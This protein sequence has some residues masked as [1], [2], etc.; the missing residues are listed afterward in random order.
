MVLDSETLR[1][2]GT[3]E[4][5]AALRAD[6][7]RY[8]ETRS[9]AL[10]DVSEDGRQM[11]VTT[12]FGQTSQVH[13]VKAPMAARTQLTFAA[14][15]A[16]S[17]RFVPGDPNAIVYVAD[18][19]GDEQYQ[20]WR[21]DLRTGRRVRLTDA[22]SRNGGALWSRD[23]A[24][25]AYSS[26]S[27]NKRDF[28]IWV[29][30][31]RDPASAQRIVD[32]KGW[33]YPLDWSRDGKKLLIGEYI[34]ANE[35]RLYVV[36]VASRAL[37]R[38][39]PEGKATY[40][41][42]LFAADGQRVYVVSDRDGEFGSLYESDLTGSSW[43]PLT[44]DIPWNV[45]GMDVS[46][47]GRT[48]A[49]TINQD[50]YSVLHLLDTRR[51]RHRVVDALPKGLIGGLQFV[52]KG[53]DTL[54]FTLSSATRSGDAYT[55][56]VRRKTLTRWTE[57]ELGGLR[58]DELV[59]P[60]L[61]R[62]ETFD[63]RSISAF[64]YA[65]E[66]AG[67]FPVIINIHG[68]PE[69]QARP[70]FSSLTQYV[71]NERKVAVLYPNV[72]GSAG[73]GKSFIALDNGKKREDS[74]K[75]IGALLDW[76]AAQPELD[77]R[78]VGVLGGSYGGYM[79]LASLVHFGERIAAGVDIVGISNF[80]TFLENTADYR[81][82]LRRVE[83]GDER[84]PDMRAHLEAISPANHAD[85]IESALFVAQ[86][87][88]DPGVPASE[89]EQI[90]AAVRAA[91]HDVWYMLAKNEGHGFR[92]KENRDLYYFLTVMFFDKHL[93]AGD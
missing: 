6:L 93:K 7:N 87:A 40:A 69:G 30:D 17:P 5:P 4:V 73:Y 86:G 83:Y 44:A 85:R 26:N 66:G 48:L 53:S 61:I 71:V 52:G 72:R 65:P 75:D 10:A 70:Y 12:R 57:S 54:G 47:D 77:Q 31:G 8:L 13:L 62:Y 49:F 35:S 27:R 56:Q 22:E 16:S 32:A 81:R 43:R 64:Y 45:E 38:I 24:Q 80:V 46:P 68:G 63:G 3:P 18:I 1:L 37:T 59:E 42:A 20:I 78:R 41:S 67:P 15:P 92:K 50:G 2:E 60:E 90:L 11:L 55:Y 51:R 89:A 88:N 19:G 58:S 91:G 74:V 84:D 76:V 33:W 9:A 14:E 34:S 28:D 36:D 21:L 79:V 25:M 29:S 23:G 82:D 39:S